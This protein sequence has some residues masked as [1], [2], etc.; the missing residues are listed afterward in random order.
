MSLCSSPPTNSGWKR[1]REYAFQCKSLADSP[2]SIEHKKKEFPLNILFC[3]SFHLF[4]WL[5]I[6]IRCLSFFCCPV[7]NTS[8]SILFPHELNMDSLFSLLFASHSFLYIRQQTIAH[9]HQDKNDKWK[10][11]WNYT[12]LMLLS[13]PWF[14]MG[15]CWKPCSTSFSSRCSRWRRDS[16][17]SLEF[18]WWGINSARL[19]PPLTSVFLS[20]CK[21]KRPKTQFRPQDF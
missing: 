3:W 8:F 18:S 19:L 9:H 11:N 20:G 4:T 16:I 1:P 2:P 12:S 7:S 6:Q 5:L 17:S 15:S 14:S 21:F 10:S 13:F